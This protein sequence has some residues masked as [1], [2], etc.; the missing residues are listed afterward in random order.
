MA[1]QKDKDYHKLR[2]PEKYAELSKE[3]PYGHLNK[4][5]AEAYTRYKLLWSKYGNK[6]MVSDRRRR[7]STRKSNQR[8]K[9]ILHQ[10]ER[11]QYKSNLRTHLV[12]QDKP[13]KTGV[14]NGSIC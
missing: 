14:R 2:N 12:D 5:A 9:Q 4:E 7:N 13:I 3:D 8:D 6:S 1:S 11:A 10:I